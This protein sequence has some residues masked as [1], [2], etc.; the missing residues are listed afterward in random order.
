MGF[1]KSCNKCQ[2]QKYKKSLKG[3]VTKPLHSPDFASRG[4]VDLIDLQTTSD[5]NRPI[6]S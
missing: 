2:L 4:Q 1:L 5:M 3:T 6:T